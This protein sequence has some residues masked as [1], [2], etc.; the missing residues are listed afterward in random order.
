MDQIKCLPCPKR[1]RLVEKHSAIEKSGHRTK[2]LRSRYKIW[3]RS[4]KKIWIIRGCYLTEEV[5]S[6]WKRMKWI[7][8]RRRRGRPNQKS[9]SPGWTTGTPLTTFP[10]S[11]IRSPIFV[12]I[13]CSFVPTKSTICKIHP[14]INIS[15]INISHP[16]SSEEIFS[17]GQEKI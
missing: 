11:W 1:K 2:I 8:K 5:L 4:Y 16:I 7:K 6:T 10:L 14:L 17:R 3:T 15:I 13:T 12:I 9:S